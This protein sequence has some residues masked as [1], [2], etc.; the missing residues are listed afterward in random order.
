M[1]GLDGKTVGRGV[2]SIEGDCDRLIVGAFVET[3]VGWIVGTSDG[4]TV[5][6]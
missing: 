5:G 4:S 3:A 6:L 2:D 1:C